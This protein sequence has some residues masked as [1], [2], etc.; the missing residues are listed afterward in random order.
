MVLR[1][2]PTPTRFPTNS[3]YTPM[4]NTPLHSISS[5]C[6]PWGR[7]DRSQRTN[8]KGQEFRSGST[9]EVAGSSRGGVGRVSRK[10]FRRR[11]SRSVS[12]GIEGSAT[13][14]KSFTGS[15]KAVPYT[16]SA[17]LHSKSLLMAA[18][19]PS[20]TRGRFSTQRSGLD[21]ARSAPL[22]WR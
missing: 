22:R 16:R 12:F 21:W 9:R 5:V 7:R 6:H 3:L 11:K 19:Q 2:K 14:E 1:V 10:W 20:S 15:R 13:G 4:D 17:A 18:R 8:T